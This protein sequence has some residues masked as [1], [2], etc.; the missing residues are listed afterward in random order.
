MQK[1]YIAKKIETKWQKEWQKKNVYRASSK[2]DKK[3]YYVLEMF[4][5]PSGKIHMGHVRVYTLGDVLA[6]YKRCSGYNVLHPMGWDAFGMP[7]EN[8]AFEN[9]IHPAVWTKQNIDNMRTQLKA[10]GLSYDWDLEFATCD[11]LYI[12]C[13]QK[14]FL[15]FYKNNLAYRRKAWANWDPVDQTVLSNEQVIDGKGWRSGAKVER[16]KLPQWFFKI[17]EY[18]DDLIDSL[19]ELKN[20]SNQVKV[21]Q[22]N[23]IGRSEG[24][25]IEFKIEKI[26]KQI[27]AENIEVYTTRPDTIYGASFIA[28]APDHPISKSLAASNKELQRFISEC[29]QIG[30]SEEALEKEEKKGFNTLIKVFHPLE[31]GKFLPVY[32]ANF[33]LMSYGTGAIFGVPAHDQRDLD[34]ANKLNLPIKVVV[35][36]TSNKS[37]KISKV[38]FT[39]DGEIINSGVLNGMNTSEAKSHVMNLIENKK[40]GKRSKQF[41]LHDWCASR[42]RYWGCPV[43][44]ILCDECGIVPV[45][46]TQLPVLLPEDVTFDKIGNPLDYHEDWKSVKCPK[47]NKNAKRETQTFDTFVDSSWYALRYPAPNS[48]E[49]IDK[50]EMIK[51]SPP[52][53]YV[54]GIEHAILHLLYSRFFNRGLKKTKY[55]DFDEPFKGLFCQGM[56]CHKTFKGPNGWVEPENVRFRGDRAFLKSSNQELKIGR[57]EKM[58]K[59]KKNIVDPMSI[60]DKYGADTARLFMLSDSPPERDLDWSENGVDGC[61]KYLKKIWGHFHNYKFTQPNFSIL[62]DASEQQNKIRREIHT[63][64][65]NTTDSIESFRYNSAVAS[66][67]KLSNLLLNL[68]NIDSNL[69]LEQIILEGWQSYLIMLSPITPHIAEELWLLINKK[70]SILLQKWPEVNRELLKEQKIR[71]AIQINGKLKNTIEIEQ[72]E[73][74]DR[75]LQESKAMALDNIKSA[76]T[77]K[78]PKKIIVIP[79]RVINIVL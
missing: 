14:I 65:Q 6:R 7:A 47:C 18:A 50:K 22:K 3:N 13:Q 38:A 39:G 48:K 17:T 32:V 52:D 11:P 68:D 5:Y 25:K 67:R 79:G 24:L 21:M 61:W 33:V 46:I 59:S 12:E 34:F 2:N 8:A 78:K 75:A 71:M 36:D 69:I 56:V 51:W 9:K 41:R 40:I 63:C 55:V 27:D 16:R 1:P 35:K 66:I 73:I 28:I 29:N 49:P 77:K 44:I 74:K 20:W 43:P 15:D 23:W 26:N 60:I 53:Q 54:G 70:S 62:K 58:S 57:S 30:T 37:E 4:P 45:P 42:Q 10:M 64:I 31:E 19:D 76:T 72:K